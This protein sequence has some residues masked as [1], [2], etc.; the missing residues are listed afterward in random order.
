MVSNYYISSSRTKTEGLDF[1][2]SLSYLDKKLTIRNTGVCK[3]QR[4][5]MTT[6]DKCWNAE[7]LPFSFFS[8]RQLVVKLEYFFALSSPLHCV[9]IVSEGEFFILFVCRDVAS[10]FEN[11]C[12]ISHHCEDTT[13]IF[14]GIWTIIVDL[15]L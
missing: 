8:N 7:K 12:R 11:Y 5:H 3:V 6:H 2:S 1:I 15:D 4:Q 13:P 9:E 10:D 14:I